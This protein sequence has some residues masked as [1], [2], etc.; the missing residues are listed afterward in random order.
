MRKAS[1]SAAGLLC[2]V[3]LLCLLSAIGMTLGLVVALWIAG[4]IFVAMGMSV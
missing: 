2:L 3:G 4:F 1:D